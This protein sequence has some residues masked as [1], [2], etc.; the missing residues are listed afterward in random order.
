MWEN[1]WGTHTAWYVL[2]HDAT[3]CRT[4]KKFFIIYHNFTLLVKLKQDWNFQS[5]SARLIW[6]KLKKVGKNGQDG[7]KKVK[8]DKSGQKLK[9]AKITKMDKD[10][11]Y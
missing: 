1:T 2:S 10:G 8:N 4:F 11:Q 9:W 7:Q 3:S 5:L 6:T